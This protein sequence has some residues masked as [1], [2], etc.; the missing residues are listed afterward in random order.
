VPETAFVLV[1]G[2]GATDDGERVVDLLALVRP[3]IDGKLQNSLVRARSLDEAGSRVDADRIT[4]R[5]GQVLRMGQMSGTAL[6][7]VRAVY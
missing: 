1:G 3:V 2:D 6:G 5:A 7:A 4:L